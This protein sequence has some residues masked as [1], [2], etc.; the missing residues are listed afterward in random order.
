MNDLLQALA[1]PRGSDQLRSPS[2]RNP[3]DSL[4]RAKQQAIHASHNYEQALQMYNDSVTFFEQ[5]YTPVLNKVQETDKNYADFIK[6]K[7]EKF[8]SL[9]M[10]FG[11]LIK[12]NGDELNQNSKIINSQTD[13]EIFIE[14]NKSPVPYVQRET[15]EAF[16]ESLHGGKKLD[17][18][19]RQGSATS[20]GS[21]QANNPSSTQGLTATTASDAPSAPESEVGPDHRSPQ[22]MVNED[23]AVKGTDP[24]SSSQ[25]E[26]AS[27]DFHKIDPL[28]SFA[29]DFDHI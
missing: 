11:M 3:Y 28:E 7:M 19:D 12:K 8:S 17:A 10:Q 9:I 5:N 13:L 20:G 23:H 15:F 4:G 27:P 29:A 6:T 26:R 2:L 21:E 24:A 25:I 1:S 14:T 16:D 22:Q 18:S